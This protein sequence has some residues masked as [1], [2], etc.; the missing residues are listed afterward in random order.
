MPLFLLSVAFL[1]CARFVSG[2]E[3]RLLGGKHAYEGRVEVLH[4]EEWRAICDHGWNFKA[5]KVVCRM[6]GFPD[7]LRYTKGSVISY[8]W[9]IT[10]RMSN[11]LLPVCFAILSCGTSTVSSA[12]VNNTLFHAQRESTNG[13]VHE[14]YIGLTFSE[15]CIFWITAM[16]Q[17]K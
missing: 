12:F 17:Q 6:L 3:V 11:L 7:A 16:Q 2:S 13:Y 15:S 1:L 9:Q 8:I 10:L 14:K 5:A 4:N